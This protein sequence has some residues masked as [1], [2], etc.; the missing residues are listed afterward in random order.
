MTWNELRELAAF[1]AGKGCAVSLYVDLDPS[2]VPTPP[3][4]QTKVNSVLQT[5]ERQ[6]EERKSQLTRDQREGLK[7]DLQRIADWFDDGF[8]RQGARG[9]AVF[10]DGL[11]NFWATLGLPEAGG[12]GRAGPENP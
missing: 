5:A 7:Q 10:A 4:V 9:V 1:R 12:G 6:L 11:A 8:D 2:D 3:D